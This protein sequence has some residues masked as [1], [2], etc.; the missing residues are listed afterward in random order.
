MTGADLAAGEQVPA[1]RQQAGRVRVI[2]KKKEKQ[3]ER[4]HQV[5]AKGIEPLFLA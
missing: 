3:P 4:E 1:Y 2:V 5:P